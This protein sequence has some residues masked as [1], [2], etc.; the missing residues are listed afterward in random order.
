MDHTVFT[1]W[2]EIENMTSIKH[3][4]HPLHLIDL[5]ELSTYL[6]SYLGTYVGRC[7]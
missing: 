7:T 2:Y 4:P 3:V 1:L 5:L 6:V